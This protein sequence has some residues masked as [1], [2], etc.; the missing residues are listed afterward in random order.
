MMKYY[1]QYIS[2]DVLNHFV[3]TYKAW[4][5]TVQMGQDNLGPNT[6]QHIQIKIENLKCFIINGFL[7]NFLAIP[8][9]THN[10]GTCE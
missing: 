6:K 9:H 3:F 10:F 5:K 7:Y 8:W 1:L 4:F 2:C